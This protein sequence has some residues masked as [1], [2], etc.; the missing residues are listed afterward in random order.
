MAQQPVNVTLPQQPGNWNMQVLQLVILLV[1]VLAIVGWSMPTDRMANMNRLSERIDDVE[2]GV[3]RCVE[4]RELDSLRDTLATKENLAT[5]ERRLSDSI[6]MA[7]GYPGTP[8]YPSY[9]SYPP[10]PPSYSCSPPLC[11]PPSCPAIYGCSTVSSCP[12][13]YATT[14]SY[15]PSTCSSSTAYAPAVSYGTPI[16]TSTCCGYVAPAPVS[17]WR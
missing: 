12:A 11:P 14:T 8:P 9:S 7:R 10:Y 16:R 13:T 4:R 17:W 2:R 15:W 5:V 6:A 1:V 3:R